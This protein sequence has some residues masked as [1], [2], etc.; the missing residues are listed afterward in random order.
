VLRTR[1][2][3]CGGRQPQPTYHSIGD[4][5]EAIQIDFDPAVI[6]YAQL[7]KLALQE[8]NFGGSVY[9]R[10]YRS[11]VFWGDEKQ[12]QQAQALGIAEL[13]PLGTFTR[14][15]DYHQKYY[16][17]QSGVVKEFYK[18]YPDAKAFTDSTA[19][20]RA[21]AIVGG[22]MVADEA[23]QVAPRLGVSEATQQTLVR[24]AKH[25]RPA[26]CGLPQ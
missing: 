2:G 3:Y 15:E 26:S 6:A 19:V 18:L 24:L 13:E 25:T 9:S 22:H 12:R 1:V 4:H 7:L 16:L 11:A 14:A 23:R 20:T 17:Q 5:S 10:Q 21:N 8:G